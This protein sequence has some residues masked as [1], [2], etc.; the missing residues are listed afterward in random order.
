MLLYL[1]RRLTLLGFAYCVA[2]ARKVL[3]LF[4]L[5]GFNGKSVTR[6]LWRESPFCVIFAA[7]VDR[8]GYD[9]AVTRFFYLN[10]VVE[11]DSTPEDHKLP[12]GGRI[13]VV[14]FGWIFSA[15]DLGYFYQWEEPP[16]LWRG[17]DGQ[18]A[19]NAEL[20]RL[21]YL[22]YINQMQVRVDQ[23]AEFFSQLFGTHCGNFYG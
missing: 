21:N 5:V 19:L 7:Y 13:N 17:V 2:M 16:P 6:R 3:V 9:Q 1:L 10:G 18:A 22:S 15:V 8:A 14:T 11:W 12:D 23:R 4:L 20:R